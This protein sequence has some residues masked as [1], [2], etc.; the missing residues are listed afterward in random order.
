MEIVPLYPHL[1][2]G[3][4][5]LDTPEAAKDAQEAK[6]CFGVH[7]AQDYIIQRWNYFVAPLSLFESRCLH[8]VLD[9][10]SC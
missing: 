6:V 5:V 4:S 2:S 9:K 7:A 8:R 10:P 3:G 1:H